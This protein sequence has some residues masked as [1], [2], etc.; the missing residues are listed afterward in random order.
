M[1]RLWPGQYVG[2]VVASDMRLSRTILTV[3]L[4]VIAGITRCSRW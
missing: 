1:S 4:T 3:D 2:D